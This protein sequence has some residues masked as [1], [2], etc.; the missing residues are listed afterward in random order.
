MLQTVRQREMTKRSNWRFSEQRRLKLE[1]ELGA[2]ISSAQLRGHPRKGE[3][4]ISLLRKRK[5]YTPEQKYNEVVS[6]GAA[7]QVR[8]RRTKGNRPFP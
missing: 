1:E 6:S 3:P 7:K 5:T 4:S 2:S 8:N